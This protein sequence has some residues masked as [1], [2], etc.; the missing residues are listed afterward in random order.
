MGLSSY[1]IAQRGLG[2]VPEGRQVFP[3]LTVRENLIATAANR[4]GRADPWSLEEIFAM[5]PVLAERRRQMAGTLSGGE[6]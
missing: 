6:Q 3:N 5:F 4:H 2:L 1:K